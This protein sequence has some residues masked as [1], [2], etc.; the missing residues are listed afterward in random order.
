VAFRPICLVL[1][2]VSFALMLAADLARAQDVP[3]TPAGRTANRETPEAEMDDAR[4]A[5]EQAAAQA[6]FASDERE[7]ALLQRAHDDLS[8][9]IDQLQGLQRQRTLDL[10]SD[11]DRAMHRTA[12]ELGRFV[13]PGEESF[14]PL[15]PSRQLLNS[16]ATEALEVQQNAPELQRLPDTVVI[17]VGRPR[18]HER[19]ADASAR[20]P[21][22]QADHEP[23][24][25][26]LG[27]EAAWPDIAIPF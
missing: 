19:T 8:A 23:L 14:G 15:V 21:I 24:S 10:L 20:D 6:D 16:L 4:R 3:T 27:F 18:Q 9:A 25:W 11:L 5:L 2:T 17:G 12:A 1:A 13:S 26:P 22:E 7:V